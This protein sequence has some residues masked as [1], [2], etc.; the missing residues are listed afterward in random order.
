MGDIVVLYHSQEHGNTEAMAKAVA[1]GAREAGATV[2]L[3]NTN[4][5]RFDPAAY[6]GF[7]AVAFGTPDYFGYIAG[8]LKTFADDWYIAKGLDRT[9]LEGKPYGLFY[10]HGGGGNVRDPFEKL[11][12][13]IGG[14]KIGDAVE[15]RGKPDAAVLRACR[16]LG[17]RLAKAAK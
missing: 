5:R 3:A 10:S 15:S 6:R 14:E 17:A 4:M 1:E 13:Y 8:T 16:E 9:G 12:K 7:D 2:T 11:F